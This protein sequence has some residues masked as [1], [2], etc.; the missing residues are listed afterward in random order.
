[1]EGKFYFLLCPYISREIIT[2][3]KEQVEEL[4]SLCCTFWFVYHG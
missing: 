3:P 4:G 2:K 1:M